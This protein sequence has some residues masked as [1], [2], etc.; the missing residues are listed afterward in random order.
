MR[1]AGRVGCE[2]R[3]DSHKAPFL[4]APRQLLPGEQLARRSRSSNFAFVL[5]YNRLHLDQQTGLRVVVKGRGVG[6][7][8]DDPSRDNSSRTSIW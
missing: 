2:E 7:A 3:A 5:G 8:D 6:E 4:G 1:W